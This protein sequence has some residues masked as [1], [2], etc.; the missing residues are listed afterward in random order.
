ML[1]PHDVH[2][3]RAR[4]VPEQRKRTLRL[5]WER[6]PKRFVHGNPNPQPLPEEVRINP[7]AAAATP[8]PTQ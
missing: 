2:Y 7:P 6:H 1:A 4:R 8:T 5:A 3:G